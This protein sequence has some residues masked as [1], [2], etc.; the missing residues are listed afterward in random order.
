MQSSAST[1]ANPQLCVD[2][3][4]EGVWVYSE[5]SFT[6]LLLLLQALIR[7]ANQLSYFAANTI[8]CKPILAEV[9]LHSQGIR[10]FNHNCLPVHSNCFHPGGG[11]R[12][13][14]NCVFMLH[15]FSCHLFVSLHF[16]FFLSLSFD[17]VIFLVSLYFTPLHQPPYFTLSC[18]L[19]SHFS[20][21]SNQP[22]LF[23]KR[24]VSLF[25]LVN[26][27][28]QL[29]FPPHKQQEFYQRGNKPASAITR[30]GVDCLFVEDRELLQRKA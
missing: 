5:L 10:L 13:L 25:A 9:Y 26:L 17:M 24:L 11:F 6:V 4:C 21:R 8:L 23:H 12:G 3:F 22:H 19:S 1:S 7:G 28:P 14:G 2:V 15:Q 18:L 27:I 20:P 30:N 16:C 29:S